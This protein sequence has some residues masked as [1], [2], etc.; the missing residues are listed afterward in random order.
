MSFGLLHV[1]H[2]KFRSYVYLCLPPDRT[3]HKVKWHKGRI[4][5]TVRGG[6]GRIR[7]LLE[8][9]SSILV[10]GSLGAMW[11]DEP[12]WTWTR[13]WV[14]ITDARFSLKLDREIQCYTKVSIIQLAHTKVIQPKP[15][16]TFSHMVIRQ[17]YMVQWIRHLFGK[18]FWV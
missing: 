13:T 8:P 10:I 14:Q 15:R 5:V 16:V 12:C 1:F 3:W 18:F 7:A 6:E 4:I 2:I 17:G 9:C 11:G